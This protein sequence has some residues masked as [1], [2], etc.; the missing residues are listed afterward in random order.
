MTVQEYLNTFSLEHDSP[1]DDTVLL[2]WINYVELNV[3]ED[4]IK[5]YTVQNYA[6]VLN[7]YQ[8]DL[9][10]GVEFT[11]VKSL[12]VNGIK[13]KKKDVR[14]YH[15]NRS[16]WFEGG[17]LCIYPACAETDLPGSPK[18]RLVYLDKPVKKKIENIA[19]NELLIPDRFQDIYDY[20]LMAKIAHLSGESTDYTNN[21]TLFNSRVAQFAQWW[22]DNRAQ[23]PVDE[24]VS[25]GEDDYNYPVGFDNE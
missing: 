4:T 5:R 11:D 6:R 9:P 23:N 17:K 7:A 19:M 1:Y 3:F 18:I 13:Y 24:M 22:E 16:Y 15:E 21:M 8:F 25:S 2:K 12:R 20:Y 10:A 14:A